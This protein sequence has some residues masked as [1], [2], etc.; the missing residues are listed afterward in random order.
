M[1]SYKGV[2]VGDSTEVMG[3]P[4]NHRTHSM[5][6]ILCAHGGF[7][8]VNLVER[9][10]NIRT[11]LRALEDLECAEI[12]ACEYKTQRYIFCQS[13]YS[14]FYWN[15]YQARPETGHVWHDFHYAVTA[16]ALEAAHQ[17]W[18][19]DAVEMEHLVGYCDYPVDM[20]TTWLEVFMNL[21][22]ARIASPTR[23]VIDHGTEKFFSVLPRAQIKLE[24][25]ERRP[26]RAT[27]GSCREWDLSGLDANRQPV[28]GVRLI[29]FGVEVDMRLGVV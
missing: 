7:A 27:L 5:P 17:L 13:N 26:H 2:Q 10:L 19:T 6:L 15:R 24:Q 28:E 25:S 16:A 3:L 12:L 29:S 18:E 9:D 20:V 23:I 8:T 1:W 21:Q 14:R 11:P 4:V 22:D